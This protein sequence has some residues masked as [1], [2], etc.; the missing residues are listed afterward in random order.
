[1]IWLM[2][3]GIAEPFGLRADEQRALT[4]QGRSLVCAQINQNRAVLPVQ[5]IVH[6]PYRRAMETAQLAGQV[7][8][9]G[10]LVVDS[11]LVPDSSPLQ[12]LNLLEEY[13][14]T[15]VL[16]VTHN[17]LVGRLIGLLCEG[18]SRRPEPMDT[19]ML[20]AIE[21]DWPASGMGTLRWKKAA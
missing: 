3:H 13:A 5:C 4:E 11:R 12:A 19:A 2:R 21:C 10:D 6:S 20:A 7:L 14:D 1:M 15:Q 17:P 9:V 18:D 8:G 16:Y